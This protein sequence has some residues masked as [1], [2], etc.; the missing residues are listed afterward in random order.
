MKG[1]GSLGGKFGMALVVIARAAGPVGASPAATPAAPQDALVQISKLSEEA[2]ASI[3]DA[4][5]TYGDLEDFG[6]H[7][8]TAT[9]GLLDELISEWTV[10]AE[11]ADVIAPAAE[12]PR[13]IQIQSLLTKA[14]LES[15]SFVN[16]AKERSKGLVASDN[17]VRFRQRQISLYSHLLRGLKR[18][19]DMLREVRK[20]SATN[21]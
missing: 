18:D 13:L 5:G 21:P 11:I 9:R 16:T 14:R 10:H 12:D 17:A 4:L 15:D 8:G 2:L 1:L 19:R 3:D 20:L 6:D 7:Y